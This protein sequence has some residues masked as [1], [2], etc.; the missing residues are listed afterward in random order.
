MRA[1]ELPG[2]VPPVPAAVA[3]GHRRLKAVPPRPENH[4]G[5]VEREPHVAPVTTSEGRAADVHGPDA[6]RGCA[7]RPALPAPL[8]RA[9]GAALPP[10]ALPVLGALLFTAGLVLGRHTVPA[11]GELALV[12]PAAGVAAT[13]FGLRRRAGARWSGALLLDTALLTCAAVL[14]HLDTGATPPVALAATAATLV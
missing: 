6:P 2:P 14:V 4:H 1:P 8:R 5:A 7:P 9:L 13:W 12:S 11:G 10:A 3:H